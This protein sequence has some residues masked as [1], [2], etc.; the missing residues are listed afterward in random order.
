MITKLSVK[1]HTKKTQHIAHTTAS[2]GKLRM[3]NW[4]VTASTLSENWTTQTFDR[5]SVPPQ[6]NNKNIYNDNISINYVH[7]SFIDYFYPP[8]YGN[9]P[10]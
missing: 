1:T 10:V 7:E 5:P 6:S 9:N 4:I 2:L 8:E 3:I